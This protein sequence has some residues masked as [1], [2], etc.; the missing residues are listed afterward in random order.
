MATKPNY[1]AKPAPSP[2]AQRSMGQMAKL[3]NQRV[4]AP[5]AKAKA[6]GK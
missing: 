3:M 4:T 6:K 2:A 5:E 1:P